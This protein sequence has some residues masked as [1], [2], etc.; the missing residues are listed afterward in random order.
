M[1][2]EVAGEE[3]PDDQTLRDRWLGSSSVRGF[4]LGLVGPSEFATH[5][6]EEWRVRVSPEDFLSDL[7]TWIERPYPGAE[8]LLADLRREHHVSCLTNCNELH[9]AALSP[10]LTQFDSSFSSHL[11]GRIKPDAGAYQAVLQALDVRPEAVRFFDDSRANVLGARAV[12]M[13]G[14]L[15]H[16]PAEVRSVLKRER[17]L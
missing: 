11:L 10:F 14:F 8:E 7:A 6:I 16:A 3:G 9:W 1:L 12:G 17:L 4:E 5:F 13:K 2:S 15:V